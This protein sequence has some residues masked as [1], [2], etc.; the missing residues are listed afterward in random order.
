MPQVPSK[1]TPWQ[2]LKKDWCDCTRCELHERRHRVVLAKGKIP[3]DVLMVGEAPGPSEDVHGEPFVG[4]A[5]HLLDTILREAGAESFRLAFTNL[6]ACIPM[7][8][9][10]DKFAQP[11]KESIQ[12]CAPRLR[13]FAEMCRP[14]LVVMVGALAAKWFTKIVPV[15]QNGHTSTSRHTCEII[16]PAAILRMDISQ[17]GLAQQRAITTIEDALYVAFNT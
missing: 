10:G 14:K 16:H 2:R 7:A 1:L 11:P 15:D 12:E 13:S 3:C 5:G 17:Q 6:V 9:E 4:P 8:E